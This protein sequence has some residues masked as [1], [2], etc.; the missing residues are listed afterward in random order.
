MCHG[1]NDGDSSAGV[2]L[3]RVSPQLRYAA[4]HLPHAAT[5]GKY[6]CPGKENHARRSL[7]SGTAQAPFGVAAPD[8][9]HSVQARIRGFAR[10]G[11]GPGNPITRS[12]SRIQGR[13]GSD[14]EANIESE[15]FLRRVRAHALA[16]SLS[17]IRLA[18]GDFML[19]RQV[20]R[21]TPAA[22][23]DWAEDSGGD[24]TPASQAEEMK[25]HH[26]S[27]PQWITPRL[28]ARRVSPEPP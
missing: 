14:E 20:V 1:C 25:A 22:P 26:G 5:R 16:L 7:Y 9:T 2:A 27:G 17:P 15:S 8:T 12:R 4:E 3:F 23:G 10:P 13:P 6:L 21:Y 11:R 24:R 18:I 19:A 28:P